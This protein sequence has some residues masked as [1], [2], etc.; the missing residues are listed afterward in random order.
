MHDEKMETLQYP[1]G[2]F[3]KPTEVSEEDIRMAIQTISDFPEKIQAAVEKMDKNQMDTPYRPGGWTVRQLVHHCADSHMNAYIRFKL[4]L[5]EETPTIKPYDQTRWAMLVDSQLLDPG[6]SLGILKGIHAR[7]ET[8][9]HS[10]SE[11]DWDRMFLH[12]EYKVTQ[13]L[14]NI[15]KMYEW[16]CNHHL[17]HIIR[18][19]HR[20]NW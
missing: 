19:I 16:H 6:V 1:I 14:K 17:S 9:M 11:E 20:M 8:I 10:M 5:T 3:T 12:P 13:S 15:V 2:R 18:L 4:T 7:W